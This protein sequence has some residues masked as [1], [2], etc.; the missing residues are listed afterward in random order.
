MID[1]KVR[2]HAARSS[3][4]PAPILLALGLLYA[5]GLAPLPQGVTSLGSA[6]RGALLAGQELP[7][8]GPGFERAMPGDDTRYAVPLLLSA[9]SRAARSVS[10]TYPGTRP[11]RVGDLSA[12]WGGNH[13]RHGSH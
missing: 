7:L 3:G 5:C 1:R 6:N 9:L 4:L 13:S 12:R 11:L 8:A 10:D 2:V